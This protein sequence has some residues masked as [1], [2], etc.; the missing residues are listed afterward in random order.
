[1]RAQIQQVN[2]PNVGLSKDPLHPEFPLKQ[3]DAD[4]L[5]Q[6][7]LHSG[8]VKRANPSNTGFH[9]DLY[10]P[11]LESG[12]MKRI[13]TSASEIIATRII[14][15]RDV[16][17]LSNLEGEELAVWIASFMIRTPKG[18]E[19]VRRNVERER[20]SAHYG[21]QIEH[22]E[23]VKILSEFKE[24]NPKL[25]KDVIDEF[26]EVEGVNELLKKLIERFQ[27][28]EI[29]YVPAPHPLFVALISEERM[30]YFAKVLLDYQWTWAYSAYGFVMS[31]N[32]L[33][34]WDDRN[35]LHDCGI[36]RRHVEITFPIARNLSLV[37][38][39]K[40]E[41]NAERVRLYSRKGT[42]ILNYR[43]VVG[44]FLKVFGPRDR[45]EQISKNVFD[46]PAI[47]IRRASGMYANPA[48]FN[49]QSSY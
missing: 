36:A 32:P 16:I 21:L 9:R 24:S 39:S 22:A 46:S 6:I 15:S 3:F 26:G 14:G 1:M 31:D 23:K 41:R 12:L 17:R 27:R 37:L 13:D 8:V 33:S 40:H 11:E 5:Y 30:R 48:V 19:V 34:R 45:I 28:S 42:R 29:D 38:Q 4:G 49:T 20:K 2:I 7:N 25:Y 10:P 43:Q 47:R 44:A 35:R 18:F